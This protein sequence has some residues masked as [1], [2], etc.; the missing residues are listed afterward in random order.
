MEED[1]K[2]EVKEEKVQVIFL[3]NYKEYVFG[4]VYEMSPE[5][6]APY[7]ILGYAKGIE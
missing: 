3:G 2:E 5:E 1:I 7:L 4:E 6:A